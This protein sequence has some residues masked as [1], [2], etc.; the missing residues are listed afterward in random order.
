MIIEAM[1]MGAEDP[2][3]GENDKGKYA[4][5]NVHIAMQGDKPRCGQVVMSGGINP[6]DFEAGA[7][8]QKFPR[9]CKVGIQVDSKRPARLVS[10]TCE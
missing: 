7:T 6:D 4:F 2:I 10:V 9:R 8:P 5:Q 1:L 3:T